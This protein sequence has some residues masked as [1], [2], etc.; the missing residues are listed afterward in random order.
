MKEK[1][2]MMGMELAINVPCPSC[3]T[4]FTMIIAQG[5]VQPHQLALMISIGV[6][7]LTMLERIIYILLVI[8]LASAQK[9]WNHPTMDVQSCMTLSVTY[10][11]GYHLI[12]K[13]MRRLKPNV[14]QKEANCCMSWMK[15]SM[16]DL[17]KF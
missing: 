2:F 9:F 13:L 16:L 1:S 7:I 12:L 6:L 17:E 4:E 8:Q 15:K 11:S 5:K 3:M 14:N 10:V